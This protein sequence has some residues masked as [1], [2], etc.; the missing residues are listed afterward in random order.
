MHLPPSTKKT[1]PPSSPPRGSTPTVPPLEEACDP[2]WIDDVQQQPLRLRRLTH[3]D[4]AA[5]A[6][7]TGGL[8][9]APPTAGPSGAASRRRASKRV[10]ISPSALRQGA[11]RPSAFLTLSTGRA[12]V[13]FVSFFLSAKGQAMARRSPAA[14]AIIYEGALGGLTRDQTN[15]R[16]KAAGFAT[17]AVP[18]STYASILRNEVPLFLEQPECLGEFIIHPRPRAWIRERRERGH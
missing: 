13:R 3:P 9:P 11:Q 5:F 7:G 4:A 18:Q 6:A 16:L 17:Q 2:P 1:R 10:S 12:N 8:R 15:A 14:R